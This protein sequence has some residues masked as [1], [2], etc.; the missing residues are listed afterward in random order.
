MAI[1]QITVGDAVL[2]VEE[3]GAGRPLLLVH[4]FPLDHTMW[5]EQIEGLSARMRVIAPDLRGFGHSQG[6]VGDVLTMDRLADDL[7]T[8]LD[9]MRIDEPI[10]FCGLSMGGYIGWRFA[11]RHGDRL[12]RLV[13]CDT[14]AAAD[15]PDAAKTRHET[16]QR[17]LREGSGVVAEAMKPKL[18]HP[19]TLE[20][21]PD[22]VAAMESVMLA[23][24]PKMIAAALRGMAERPDSTE[25]LP[26]LNTPSL[27]LCGEQD[28]ITPPAEMRQM[29]A[30]MPQA[31]F[32]EIPG[33]AHM[34]PLE[35][36]AHVNAAILE[37]LGS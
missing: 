28:A 35:S 26:R 5:R 19:D 33:A 20:Q 25:L 34:A 15:S 10:V 17:V 11:A 7:A 18:F 27:L 21:N 37:F 22:I 2:N 13:Q 4:G 9:A 24:A 30:A 16:A 31:T 12:W 23:T 29:A 32:L 14:R 36:P 6:E 3:E 8:L 1:D